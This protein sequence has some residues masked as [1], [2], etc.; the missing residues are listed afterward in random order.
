L[1]PRFL[2][3]IRVAKGKQP[4]EPAASGTTSGGQNRL[5]V[6]AGEMASLLGVT[7]PT[8]AKWV[9]QGA[10]CESRGRPGVSAEFDAPKF[11]AW[12]RETVL[13]QKEDKPE[14]LSEREQLADIELKELKLRKE[15]S[16]LV[17]RRAAV[18]VIRSLHTQLANV[19]RQGPRRF[20]HRLVSLPD[21]AAAVQAA[22][23]IAEDQIKDLRL[24]EAWR[25]ITETAEQSELEASV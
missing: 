8:I 5:R 3:V 10:P 9:D 25:A 16:E 23:E 2:S 18:S 4:A 20:A 6:N 21:T 11:I 7:R 24:P 22:S 13:A 1:F 15:R 19:L 14:K 12:W 17:E